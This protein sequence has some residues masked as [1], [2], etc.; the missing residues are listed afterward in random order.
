MIARASASERRVNTLRQVEAGRRQDP[1]FRAG[2]DQ[3]GVVAEALAGCRQHV[4]R[5]GLDRGDFAVQAQ[6]DP[7]FGIELGAL[8]RD[9][10]F[11]RGAGEVILGQVGAVA[12]Q[13]V[14]GAEH[15][16]APS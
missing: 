4:A 6:V 7:A 12:G 13:G 9:P 10:V 11:R 5:I 3:Q 2:G 8:Q 16:Q 15:R 14:V 1:R